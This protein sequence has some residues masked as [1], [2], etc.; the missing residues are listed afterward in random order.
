V[1]GSQGSRSPYEDLA[2]AIGRDVY[3]DLGGWHIF[4]KD[5]SVEPG[6]PAK[7]A[8]ALAAELG[9]RAADRLEERDVEAVLARVPVRLGGNRTTVPLLDLVPRAGV[10]DLTR[11]VEEFGRKR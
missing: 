5:L 11:H 7:M 6:A 1:S 3:A 8:A 2:F 9:P 4:L 10:R